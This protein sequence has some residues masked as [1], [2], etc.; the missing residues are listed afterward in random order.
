M[1]I[2]RLEIANFRGITNLALDLDETTVLYGTNNTGK[3][4]IMA[5]IHYA[6]S[7]ASGRKSGIFSE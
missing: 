7:R 5:A 2:R 3:S 6:L 4:T 1:L